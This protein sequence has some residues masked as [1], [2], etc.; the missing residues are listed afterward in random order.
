MITL[1][2]SQGQYFGPAR[3]VWPPWWPQCDPVAAQAPILLR[4]QFRKTRLFLRCQM[5][6]VVLS[7]HAGGRVSAALR[8]WR[9]PGAPGR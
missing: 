8:T 7:A 5:H 4:V 3:T 2:L 9:E 1:S 6:L